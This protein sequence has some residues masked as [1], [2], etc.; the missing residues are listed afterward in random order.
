MCGYKLN[1]IWTKNTNKSLKRRIQHKNITGKSFRSEAKKVWKAMYI[2]RYGQVVT[3]VRCLSGFLKR[4][5]VNLS[6]GSLSTE[7]F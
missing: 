1:S 5:G 6:L 3:K 7:K 2:Y 4:S